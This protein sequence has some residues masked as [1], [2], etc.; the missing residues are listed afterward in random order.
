MCINIFLRLHTRQRFPVQLY[1]SSIIFYMH[2]DP[3]LYWHI[4]VYL[5][6]CGIHVFPE[7]GVGIG[8]FN[9]IPLIKGRRKL[10]LDDEMLAPPSCKVQC[11]KAVNCKRFTYKN[12]HLNSVLEF[13]SWFWNIFFIRY[14][15]C[16][17]DLLKFQENM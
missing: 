9:T 2:T 15:C 4:F 16:L 8:W 14:I 3:V 1:A 10:S 12:I 17:L 6:R 7:W 11:T 13:K 5:W